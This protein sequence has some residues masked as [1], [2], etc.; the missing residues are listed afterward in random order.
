LFAVTYR[1]PLLIGMALAVFCQF[2]GIDAVCSLLSLIFLA[3]LVV[4][5]R[6]RSLEEIE[7]SWRPGGQIASSSS[8][9]LTGS[10]KK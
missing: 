8:L 2:S 10:I 3:L 7:A 4:K 5:T 1:R 9:S 6:G